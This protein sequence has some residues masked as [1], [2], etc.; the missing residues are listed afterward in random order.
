MADTIPNITRDQLAKF[1]PDNDT[2]RR[3]EKLFLLAGTT[4]PQ[5]LQIIFSLIQETAIDAGTAI[6]S[7][8]QANDLSVWISQA[9]ALMASAPPAQP[10]MRIDDL[11][12]P[13]QPFKQQDD[14]SPPVQPSIDYREIPWTP[15]VSFATPGDLAV[16]Y[17]EQSGVAIKIGRQVFVSWAIR[18][19]T[20]T[21][22]TAAGDLIISGLPFMP[23]TIS[24]S[25]LNLSWQGITKAGYTDLSSVAISGSAT[26]QVMACGSAVARSSV[27]VADV[28]TGGTVHL[29]GQGHYSI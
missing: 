10:E 15:V 13:T 7:A 5:N 28:P 2:I 4:T 23:G 29:I 9:L 12:P 25:P 24:Q 14:L 1:L 6:S 21:H 26:M 18:T 22:T 17:A 27:I 19:S 11:S 20:F 3:F 8:N 16:V